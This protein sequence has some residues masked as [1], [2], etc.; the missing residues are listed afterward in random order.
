MA[1]KII[2]TAQKRWRKLEDGKNQLPK[3]I[4]GVRFSDGCEVTNHA[5][6][7]VA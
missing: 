2:K 5:E 4:Q 6:R 7:A 3:V 1:F